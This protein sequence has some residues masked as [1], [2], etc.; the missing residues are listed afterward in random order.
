M[1]F[2]GA[3]RSCHLPTTTCFRWTKEHS[4]KHLRRLLM[5]IH[6]SRGKEKWT[7][8]DSAEDVEKSAKITDT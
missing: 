2:V 1:P 5:G 3:V 8:S 7:G 4:V 6:S